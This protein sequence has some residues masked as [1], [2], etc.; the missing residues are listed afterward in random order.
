MNILKVFTNEKGEYG[1]SVGIIIDTD[2]KIDKNEHQKMA[3]DSGFS[4]IV[5]INNLENKEISIYTPQREIPFAGH[6]IVGTSYF[7]NHKYNLN[8]IQLNSIG[9]PID[10][11]SENNLTWVSCSLS[12]TPNW[13]LAQLNSVDLVEKITVEEAKDK[14]HCVVW[15]WID[16]EKGLIRART[17]AADWGIPEDEANGSGSMKLAVLLNQEITIVHGKGSVIHA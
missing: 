17:F 12:I 8:I 16:K 11:W 3:T 9:G 7:L 1:N 5:F 15:A 10:T 2:N 13:N 14:E 6:A 4:E